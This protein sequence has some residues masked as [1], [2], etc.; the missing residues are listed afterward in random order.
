VYGKYVQGINSAFIHLR[1]SSWHGQ[2]AKMV[3]WVERY[4]IQL[5]VI[6]GTAFLLAGMCLYRSY[7]AHKTH[8]VVELGASLQTGSVNGSVRIG[9]K[10]V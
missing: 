8:K 2:D 4:W 5:L 3:F 9:M 1:G 10:G 7:N 6:A